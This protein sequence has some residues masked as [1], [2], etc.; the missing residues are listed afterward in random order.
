MLSTKGL[1]AENTV[2]EFWFQADTPLWHPTS[3]LVKLRL[4]RE[5]DC[6]I[7]ET[8]RGRAHKGLGPS[9]NILIN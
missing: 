5:V 3:K 4:R 2:L 6:K 1:E 8:Q 7:K 9:N